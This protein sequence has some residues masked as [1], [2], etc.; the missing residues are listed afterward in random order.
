MLSTLIL[1]EE[2]SWKRVPESVRRAV[3]ESGAPGFSDIHL[4]TNREEEHVTL[5][6]GGSSC[7]SE[8][9]PGGD[10]QGS[11]NCMRR[12]DTACQEGAVCLEPVSQQR[13]PDERL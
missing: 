12:E 10:R 3:E 6:S 2:L 4:L 13:G 7:L 8:R 1:E 5:Y 9:M 11:S